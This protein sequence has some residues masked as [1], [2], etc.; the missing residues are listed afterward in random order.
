MR[1]SISESNNLIGDFCGQWDIEELSQE[2]L[3]S[4]YGK[5]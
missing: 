1:E 5:R 4:K 2:A 3:Q